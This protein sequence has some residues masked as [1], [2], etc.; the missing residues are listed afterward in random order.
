MGTRPVWS[1]FSLLPCIDR[2]YLDRQPGK[3]VRMK[4]NVPENQT[5]PYLG[6]NDL[7]FPEFQAGDTVEGGDFTR[8]YAPNF[9]LQ[10]LV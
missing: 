3:W 1:D 8:T 6:Y 2:A 5:C 4:S 10:H 9:V 7:P